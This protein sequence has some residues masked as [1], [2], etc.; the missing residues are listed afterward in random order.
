M[1]S[2][3]IRANPRFGIGL[4]WCSVAIL[5]LLGFRILYTAL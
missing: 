5:F 1:F 2:E 4:E 3:R